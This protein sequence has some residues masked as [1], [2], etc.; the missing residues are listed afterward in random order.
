MT[1]RKDGAEQ[2]H[3]QEAEKQQDADQQRRQTVIAEVVHGVGGVIERTDPAQQYVRP[4]AFCWVQMQQGLNRLSPKQKAV[5]AEAQSAE[6]GRPAASPQSQPKHQ[7][8]ERKAVT[9]Q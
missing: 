5:D 8:R 3:L 2:L 9:K 1:D 7:K 4:K 6:K